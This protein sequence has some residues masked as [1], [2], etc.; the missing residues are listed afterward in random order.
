MMETISS[1]LDHHR[2]F[3]INQVS[4]DMTSLCFHLPARPSLP[5]SV[6][7]V[8]LTFKT[9]PRYHPACEVFL[10]ST[11]TLLPTQS[12]MSL[13]LHHASSATATLGCVF[14]STL[15]L[16][17]SGGNGLGNIHLHI[18]WHWAKSRWSVNVCWMSKVENFEEL[19]KQN[20][21]K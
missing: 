9:P 2:A 11:P 15:K 1:L 3:V 20:G 5:L 8:F 21:T 7:W 16:R 19:K 6:T 18:P 10:P 12:L 13:L 14:V 17:A 4:I